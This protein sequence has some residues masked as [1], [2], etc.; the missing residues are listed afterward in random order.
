M[1]VFFFLCCRQKHIALDIG[2]FQPALQRGM[3]WTQVILA[4]L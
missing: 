1:F 4:K 2:F 3:E